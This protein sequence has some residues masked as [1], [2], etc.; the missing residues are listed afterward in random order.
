MSAQTPLLTNSNIAR[1]S[2]PSTSHEGDAKITESGDRAEQQLKA[3]AYIREF[4]GLTA[5]ELGK[6]AAARGDKTMTHEVFHKRLPELA[7]DHDRWAQPK[8]VLAKRGPKRICTV[9]DAKAATWYEIGAEIPPA[10]GE[11]I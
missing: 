3:L 4:P 1:K 7:A 6:K 9:S 10:Q 8:A 2:D 11:L 5:R